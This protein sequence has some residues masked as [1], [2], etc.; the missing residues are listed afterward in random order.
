MFDLVLLGIFLA[1]VA[2]AFTMVSRRI[3]A[4][5]AVP[6]GE[7]RQSLALNPPM[8]S[9]VAAFARPFLVRAKYENSVVRFLEKNLRRLRVWILK[10]DTFVSRTL[11]NLQER[12]RILAEKDPQYWQGLKDWKKEKMETVI[13]ELPTPVAPPA[14]DRLESVQKLFQPKNEELIGEEDSGQKNLPE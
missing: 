3:P 8:L 2:G 5:S 14:K 11:V 10:S 1:S 6:E 7:I 13:P 9:K 12:S 4:V